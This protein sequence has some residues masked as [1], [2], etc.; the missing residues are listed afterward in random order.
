MKRAF[1]REVRFAAHRKAGFAAASRRL[2]VG[3]PF[4][5]GTLV[6]RREAAPRQ[7]RLNLPLRRGLL[8][9]PSLRAALWGWVAEAG[10]ERPAYPQTPLRGNENFQTPIVADATR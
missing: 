8:S 3:R 4:K 9:H 5:A 7:R 6:P 1:C 10:L 2:T